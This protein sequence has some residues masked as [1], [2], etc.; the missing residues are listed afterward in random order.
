MLE[1]TLLFTEFS[2]TVRNGI[3]YVQCTIHNTGIA[4]Y[5]LTALNIL[6]YTT[7]YFRLTGFWTTLHIMDLKYLSYTF[8]IKS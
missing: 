5:K 1:I 2:N 4:F 6:V 7:E 3:L 8:L